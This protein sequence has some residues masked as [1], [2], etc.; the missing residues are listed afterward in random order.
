MTTTTRARS[1]ATARPRGFKVARNS[2]GDAAELR[3]YDEVGWLGVTA[4][5]LGPRRDEL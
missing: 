5:S 1:R 2:A 4:E 3:I